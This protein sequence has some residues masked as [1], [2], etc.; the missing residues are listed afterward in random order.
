MIKL[1]E[2]QENYMK[3]VKPNFLY[4][5]DTG[6]GKTI[7]GLEHH[8]RFFNDCPLLIVA[9]ASKIN[10]GGWQRTIEEHYKNI[11]E[12]MTCTYNKLKSMYE[13][14]NK[15]KDLENYFVIF[16][17][18][19]RLKA[20]TG[21]WGKYGYKLS[22]STQGFILLSAT[23]MP[24]GWEDAINYFKMF[25]MIKNKTKF[26]QDYAVTVKRRGQYGN[27]YM[28]IVNW[29][30]KDE[31]TEKYLGFSR[32]LNKD[33]AND[34]PD[35]VFEEKYFKLSRNYK[36][37][38]KDRVFKDEEY[39]TMMKLRHGLRLHCNLKDKTE[40]VQDFLEDTTDNVVIFYN[41]VE[42]YEML[43]KAIKKVKKKM[44]V[45]N[46]EEHF[47]PKKNE[48]NRVK[49]TVTVANYKSGSEAVE[50]TYANII[51]YFSPTE[52]YTDF[53]QSYGRC[54]RNGQTKK[55]TVYK[56]ITNDSIEENIY[57]AL[58][59]KQDFNVK[60]WEKSIAK[61]KKAKKKK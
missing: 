34:L 59:N 60:L 13:E 4:D 38:L 1:Y 52:S 47:Y 17:E 55:V 33:E 8:K 56:F 40:Y 12:Y 39:D 11:K 54:Y 14:T 19:H 6:T 28:Q 16:D 44:Y 51:I 58:G 10:E 20:S 36:K 7:M 31:L 21:V 35:L 25:G 24:N 3:Y 27:N 30:N 2:Y 29:R 45:C 61:N 15:Y 43:K 22:Q 53:Y 41:Y 49:N 42:E 9:P 50:F 18:C 23:P 5:M 26:I 32:R 57:E 48:W 37:I 46:G